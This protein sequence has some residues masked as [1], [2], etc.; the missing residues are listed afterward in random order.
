MAEM[1][2][3]LEKLRSRESGCTARPKG[4]CRGWPEGRGLSSSASTWLGA[5]W[6][7]VS[8]VPMPGDRI[9]GLQELS[10]TAQPFKAS[11]PG[12]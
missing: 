8:E 4:A 6:A 3:S 2:S 10:P 11:V 5:P 7:Q 12:G 1:E 9:W